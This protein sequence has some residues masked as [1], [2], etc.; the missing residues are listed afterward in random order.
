M[1]S[2]LMFA[3]TL[4]LLT[5]AARGQSL[6][7]SDIAKAVAY[8]KQFNS[9]PDFLRDGL[10]PKRFKIAGAFATDGTS[11]YITF[12][13]DLDVISAAVAEANQKMRDLGSEELKSIPQTGL[14]FA[15]VEIHARGLI[16]TGRLSR[17]Y[18]D[19]RAHLVLK[20]GNQVI[21][22]VQVGSY[23]TPPRSECR[24]TIYLWS[25][26]GTYN[27]GVGTIVPVPL[28]C[29]PTEGKIAIEF[30]FRLTPDQMRQKA[31]AILIDGDGKR[32]ATD[33]D[34]AGLR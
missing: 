19:G 7:E 10:K 34:L 12:Y 15:N 17:R 8:G 27:F 1:R 6:S 4:T 28:P 22:P 25:V 33:V 21:Q 3:A 5:A 11:K 31:T 2:L 9:R 13:D 30:G 18:M 29:G 14:L 26:F 20:L 32:H 23:P 16:P 24:N